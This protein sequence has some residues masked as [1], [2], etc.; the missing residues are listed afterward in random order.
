M[1]YGIC[2]ISKLK[3]AGAIAA[4]ESHTRRLRPTPNA[5]LTRE[6]ERFICTEP[7]TLMLGQEVFNRIGNQ[8][9]RKDAVLCVEILLS[10]S[11]EFFRPG[12]RGNAGQ[13]DSVHLANWKKTNHDWLSEMFGDRVVRAELHLDEVTPHI[14]AYLVPLDEKGK[15]NCRGIF[16]GREKLSQFQDSY[17][18]AMKPL[19]LERGIKGSR[20]THTEIKE[21]YAAV[22]KEPDLSLTSAEMHHQIADYQRVVKAHQA[23]EQTA[24]RLEQRNKALEERLQRVQALMLQQEGEAQKWQQNYQ[25]MTGQ[26]RQIP[27]TQVAYESGLDPDWQDKQKW[28]GEIHT[29]NITGEKFYDWQ[30]MKGGGGAIDLVM[31]LQNVSF[32]EAI[33]WLGDRFGAA[34]MLQLVT[35]QISKQTQA[36]PQQPFQ[37]PALH[38]EKWGQVRDDLIRQRRIPSTLVDR[39]HQDGLVYADEQGNAVFLRRDWGGKVTGAGLHEPNGK[40]RL[41]I[42]TRRSQGCFYTISGGEEEGVVERVVLVNGAIEGLS[43]Q[44]LHPPTVRTMVLSIDGLEGL[45]WEELRAVE[46]VAIALCQDTRG[47]ELAQWLQREL[48]KAERLL[49]INQ[50]WNEDLQQRIKET[51]R[52]FR[53][54]QQGQQRGQSKGDGLSL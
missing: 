21:Y 8:T 46:R 1:P 49:P 54:R 9:I 5:D 29:I 25:A 35:Q 30:K 4:S 43:Y 12:D 33:D 42:G 3:S 22:V 47:N 48:P 16:G 39:L 38:D 27:L 37:A 19:G 51:Q 41:A 13:W 11:P 18:A 10:A 14:H 53:E 7:G 32:T 28:R 31:H 34:E 24:K 44:V 40:E 36:K 20:A 23:M 6:N 52:I 2:R 26:L 50:D 15:L 17:A 45:P